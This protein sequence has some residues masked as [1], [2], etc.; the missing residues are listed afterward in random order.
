[1]HE[2]G[3]L[4]GLGDVESTGV[5]MGPLERGKPLTKPTKNEVEDVKA[6]RHAIRE[7][8]RAAEAIQ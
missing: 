8:I 1:M 2:L 4:L 5:L 7:K 6:L 3:H